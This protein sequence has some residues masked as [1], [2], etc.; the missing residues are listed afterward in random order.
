MIDSM[1]PFFPN[2]TSNDD[3]WAAANST[4]T[5]KIHTT[6]FCHPTDIGSIVF[7]YS[8]RQRVKRVCACDQGWSGI[9]DT[10]PLFSLNFDIISYK[11]GGVDICVY[12]KICRLLKNIN[13]A[14]VYNCCKKIVESSDALCGTF[15]W[16]L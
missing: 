8:M 4:D 5:R 3:G 13:E 12:A 14:A 1:G 9:L 6:K 16:R 2:M 11:E 15:N 7:H 10:I